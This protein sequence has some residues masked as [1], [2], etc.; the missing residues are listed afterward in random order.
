MNW[1]LG[2]QREE[3]NKVQDDIKRLEAKVELLIELVDDLLRERDD[4]R[5]GRG[6]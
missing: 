2:E 5:H 4:V 3:A 6:R 1:K